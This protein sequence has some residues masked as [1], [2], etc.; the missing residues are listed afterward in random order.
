MIAKVGHWVWAMATSALVAGGCAANYEKTT[1]ARLS[2]VSYYT[3]NETVAPDPKQPPPSG[4]L[5]SYVA[6]AMKRNPALRASYQRW[7]ASVERIASRR[8]LPDPTVSYG[9]FVR[10]VETRVGPQ[11]HRFSL[12]Q[13]L[14][15][16][17]KLSTAA[18]ASA[19][20]ARAAEAR[21]RARALELRKQVAA[22][23][24]RMWLLDRERA[25]QTKQRDLLKALS[26]AVR[27]RVEIGKASLAALS[28]VD[29]SVSTLADRLRT[30]D[31]KR[32][33]ARARLIEAIGA[34]EEMPTP[35]NGSTPVI[36]M[37]K[38]ATE[39][40]RSWAL[41]HPS[42]RSFGHEARASDDT[43]RNAAA[44]RRPNF[45]VG[46]DYIETG[47]APMAGVADS[48]KDPIILSVGISLPIWSGAYASRAAAAKARAA[49]WTAGGQAARNKAVSTLNATLIELRD[50][51]RR[52][53]TYKRTLI[54]QAEG[55]YGAVVGTFQTGASS[56]ASVLLAE[57][58]LLRLRLGLVRA[59]AKHAPPW[60]TLEQVVGRALAG[61]EPS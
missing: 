49:A 19:A 54:P 11:R 61:K 45:T 35:I 3:G 37:P 55:V 38:R 4:T 43:A 58:D 56:L 30:L 20:R 36:G 44:A 7:R 23:Y 39:E 15:W 48:G 13:M 27:A 16:P 46:L 18:D 10:S 8:Q 33:M 5:A 32:R 24:W 31:A 29:L 51:Q 25:I 22:V 2:S 1:R 57:R 26:Q 52:V 53:A 21:F 14:P 12:R 59:R 9:L 47:A 50:T 60:A 40:L 28:Q 17:S 41:T 42:I 6:Y 34:P